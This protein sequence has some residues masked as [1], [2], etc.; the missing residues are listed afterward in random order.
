MAATGAALAPGASLA[1]RG[2][3]FERNPALSQHRPSERTIGSMDPALDTVFL[4][5]HGADGEEGLRRCFLAGPFCPAGGIR[6]Y[7]G[8]RNQRRCRG[9]VE[10]IW[11]SLRDHDG[12]CAA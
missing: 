2:D 9:L 4:D 11:I 5:R 12:R 10:M 1:Q 3:S 6:R 8:Q 7:S